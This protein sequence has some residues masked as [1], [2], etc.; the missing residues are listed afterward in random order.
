MSA[1]HANV[2]NAI[3]VRLGMAVRLP[4]VFAVCLHVVSKLGISD[5]LLF[6][7][8]ALILDVVAG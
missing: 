4:E 2:F 8:L 6:A 7:N 5:E 3:P 1:I